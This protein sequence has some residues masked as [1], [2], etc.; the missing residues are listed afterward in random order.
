MPKMLNRVMQTRGWWNAWSSRKHQWKGTWQ[1]NNNNSK[2]T[3]TRMLTRSHSY[4]QVKSFLWTTPLHS[5]FE[6]VF[7]K[8][9]FIRSISNSCDDH[10]EPMRKL[11]FSPTQMLLMETAYRTRVK[12]SQMTEVQK[13]TENWKEEIN[14]KKESLT[15]VRPH[16]IT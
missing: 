7:S 2:S 1:Q 10:M 16:L 8:S 5:A 9:S 6:F 3:T 13:W 15:Q 14:R 12:I 4:V 11:R